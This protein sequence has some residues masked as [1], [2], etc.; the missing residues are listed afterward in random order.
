MDQRSYVICGLGDRGRVCARG[1][2]PLPKSDVDL[3]WLRCSR[4]SPTWFLSSHTFVMSKPF[5]FTLKKR[6]RP[7]KDA[8]PKKVTPAPVEI[9]RYCHLTYYFANSPTPEK[10]LGTI[11]VNSKSTIRDLWRS[12][13]SIHD[14]K[15]T[16]L[17]FKF[18]RP[19]SIEELFSND[20][21]RGLT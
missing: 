2:F 5:D 18:K 20:R 3:L 17:F 9:N 12:L 21:H 10:R 7:R 1:N 6:G 15:R 13:M 8:P 4:T 16:Y 19:L 14:T 11:V